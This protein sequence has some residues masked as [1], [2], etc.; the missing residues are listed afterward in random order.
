[1][2]PP[3]IA[4]RHKNRLPDVDVVLDLIRN[5]G[6]YIGAGG[7]KRGR[8]KL[9]RREIALRRAA[10]QS[11]RADD[12]PV[13]CASLY[14][15]FDPEVF[16][17]DVPEDERTQDVFEELP[18]Q[19]DHGSGH[20]DVP[21]HVRVLRGSN[22]YGRRT[23]LDIVFSEC[24]A[25]DRIDDDIEASDR[26]AY[27]RFITCVGDPDI[28]GAVECRIGRTAHD[29]TNGISASGQHAYNLAAKLT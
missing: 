15:F 9:E 20:R 1:M 28:D 18:V 21:L 23:R 2:S 3:N 13:Q 24:A 17:Q 10:R 5:E 6:G 26:N 19:R 22:S 8:Q 4:R 14:D 11:R 12:R 25:A 16:C 29:C 27:L 7:R